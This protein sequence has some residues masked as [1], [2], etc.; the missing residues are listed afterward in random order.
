MV[1][2]WR[3]DMSNFNGTQKS[4]YIEFLEEAL[5]RMKELDLN[6]YSAAVEPKWWLDMMKLEREC[7][8][9]LEEMKQ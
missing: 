7:L 6:T 9:S 5:E 3:V 2:K 8:A 1:W 4:D